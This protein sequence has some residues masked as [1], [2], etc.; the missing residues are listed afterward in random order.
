MGPPGVSV[1]DADGI[2]GRWEAGSN[3]NCVEVGT[4]SCLKWSCSSSVDMG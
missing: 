2:V 3:A 4:G 1:G